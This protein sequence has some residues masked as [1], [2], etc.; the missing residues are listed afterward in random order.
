MNDYSPNYHG[1]NQHLED[2]IAE[3]QRHQ[4]QL[5]QE[6]AVLERRLRQ[7]Q[8]DEGYSESYASTS[9]APGHRESESL[10]Q[11][12]V[13]SLLDRNRRLQDQIAA[14]ERRH[15]RVHEGRSGFDRQLLPHGDRNGHLLT[16][17]E[18]QRNRTWPPHGRLNGRGQ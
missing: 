1:P 10:L 8:P 12:Q 13:D 2:Q 5:E 18:L 4:E 16:D 9:A 6:R 3:F 14:N 15:E 17:T 11:H 7:Q